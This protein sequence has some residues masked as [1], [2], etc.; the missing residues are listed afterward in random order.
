MLSTEDIWAMALQ[1]PHFMRLGRFLAQHE[2]QPGK[3]DALEQSFKEEP[4]LN[5]IKLIHVVDPQMCLKPFVILWDNKAPPH[6]NCAFYKMGIINQ[7]KKVS[8]MDY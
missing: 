7:E 8:E 3:E 1:D 4:W 2:N 5:W 6:T